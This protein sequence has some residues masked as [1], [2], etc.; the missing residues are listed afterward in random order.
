MS[1]CLKSVLGLRGWRGDRGTGRMCWLCRATFF[2]ESDSYCYDCG[3]DSKWRRTMVTMKEFWASAAARQQYVSAIWQLPGFCLSMC[4]PDFMHVSC[5]G[6]LQYLNGCVLWEIF[7][8]L[9]GTFDK[10]DAACSM[11]HNMIVI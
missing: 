1:K 3:K 5:L 4:K 2:E 6:I 11:I 9:G 8:S 7:V 10:H